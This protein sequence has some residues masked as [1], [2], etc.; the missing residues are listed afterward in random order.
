MARQQHR[1][2]AILS[3]KFELNPAESSPQ[4]AASMQ[5]AVCWFGRFWN[6]SLQ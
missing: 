1:R 2:I 3:L 6:G 5:A 4:V